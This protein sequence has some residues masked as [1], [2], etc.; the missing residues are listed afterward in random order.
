MK[1]WEVRQAMQKWIDSTELLDQNMD[2]EK[3]VGHELHPTERLDFYPVNAAGVE[4][5]YTDE[6]ERIVLVI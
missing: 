2:V 6:I 5:E 4:V 3:L 1:L